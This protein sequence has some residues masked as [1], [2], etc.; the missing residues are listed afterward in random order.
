MQAGGQEQGV[1]SLETGVICGY[2]LHSVGAYGELNLGP[3]YMGT[4]Y[5]NLGPCAYMAA[6]A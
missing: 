5:P 6:L 1:G 4:G 3:F 2:E